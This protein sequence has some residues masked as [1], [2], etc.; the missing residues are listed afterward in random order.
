MG[1]DFILYPKTSST[2]FNAV[3]R[4]AFSNLLASTSLL[5]RHYIPSSSSCTLSGPLVYEPGHECGLLYGIALSVVLLT[6][7]A[8]L[9][10]LPGPL[11]DTVGRYKNYWAVLF[12]SSSHLFPM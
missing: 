4:Q 3:L 10:V 2:T 8:F 1:M 6:T 12:S 5:D 7:E 9:V 11:G